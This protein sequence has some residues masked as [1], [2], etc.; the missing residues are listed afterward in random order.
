[1]DRNL[2]KNCR[3]WWHSPGTKFMSMWNTFWKEQWEKWFTKSTRYRASTSMYSITFCVRVMSPERHHWKPAVQ[4]AAVMSRTP[5]VDGQSPAS[6]PRPLAIYGTQCWE[7]PRHPPVTNQQ[8][9]HTPCKLGFTLCCHSNAT[10][11]PIA[12]PPNIVHN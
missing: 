11:A 2:N 10:G 7:R 9:A 4:A 8:C 3:R 1:M 6:Q 12:N 5:P